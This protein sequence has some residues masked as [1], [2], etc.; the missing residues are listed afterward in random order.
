MKLLK[1]R[2]KYL[3]RRARLRRLINEG[4][5]FETGYACEVCGEKLYDFPTYDARG[6]FKC[7]SWAEDVCGDP[8]CPMC[9]K[10]PASPLD[11][12]FESRQ[13]A[14]HALCRKRSLQDN[15]F[16][17]S[18]GAVKHRKRRLQYKKILNN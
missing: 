5:A 14:A 1:N 7:G 18:N 16:H 10:R 4:F 6:C 3:K 8:D 11:V 13:T 17:K 15:Y 2:K 9:G 12:Y